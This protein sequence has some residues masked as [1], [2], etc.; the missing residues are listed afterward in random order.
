MSQV[1]SEERKNKAMKKILI[2]LL[3]ILFALPLA[4]CSKDGNGG[5]VTDSGTE[6]TDTDS[7][8]SPVP[9]N[10]DYDN[11]VLNVGVR[12]RDD[13]AFELDPERNSVDKLVTA[14]ENRNRYAENKLNLSLKMRKLPGTWAQRADFVTAI[15]N[16]AQAGGDDAIDILFGPNYSMVG[17]MLDG[18][19]LNYYNSRYINLESSYWNGSFIDECTYDGKL[20]MLEGELTLTMLDSAFVMFC[21]TKNFRDRTDGDDLYRVVR[22]KDW[23]FEKLKEYVTLFGTENRDGDDNKK[24]K[25][26]FFGMVSPAFSCGRDGFPTA[27]GVTVVSKGAEGKITTTFSSQRNVDIYADFYRFVNENEGVFVNGNNDGAREECKAMFTAGNTVFITELLNYAGTLRAQERDYGIFPL[28]MYDD[29]QSDYYTLSE[30]VHSQIAIMAGS[31]KTEAASAALEELGYQTHTLVTDVY[32]E[33]VKYRNNRLPESIEML[34][35]ILNSVTGTFG[36]EFAEEL[37]SPFP[38][39]IGSAEN[40]SDL[41]AQKD[42]ITF[43]MNTLKRKIQALN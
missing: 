42:A 40:V 2:V 1:D 3:A 29:T 6:S 36:S 13:I 26:D 20:Y 30:A 7:G 35:I 12:D 39:P 11:L 28:P 25:E 27:F 8:G 10:L 34:N 18:M 9:D 31:A 21:D 43:L 38:S 37:R 33:T 4:A 16:D 24:T 23:T 17:L 5:K 41:N 22:E 32:Y 14:I 19:F 15:R